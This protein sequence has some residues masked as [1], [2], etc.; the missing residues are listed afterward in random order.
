[1]LAGWSRNF[2]KC[3]C[4]SS[5]KKELLYAS[6]GGGGGGDGGGPDGSGQTKSPKHIHLNSIIFAF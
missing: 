3:C 5:K 6:G 4:L 2:Q 1:M